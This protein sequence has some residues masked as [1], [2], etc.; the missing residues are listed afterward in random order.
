MKLNLKISAR[1]RWFLAMAPAVAIVG[2][3]LFGFSDGL[4]AELGKQQKRLQAA[5]TPLPPPPPSA[6]LAKAKAA[7]EEAK[8]GI[9]DKEKRIAALEERIATAARGTAAADD[10]TAPAR[11]IEKMEAVFWLV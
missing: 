1:E 10:K 6:A 7:L 3:Y 9:A 11:V 5:Q 4:S 2:I 8:R